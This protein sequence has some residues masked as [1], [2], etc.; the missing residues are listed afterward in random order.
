MPLPPFHFQRE[1]FL[2][3]GAYPTTAHQRFSSFL[4]ESEMVLCGTLFVMSA[5]WHCKGENEG[6]CDLKVYP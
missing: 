5:R 4:S 2:A 1:L 3:L 6:V